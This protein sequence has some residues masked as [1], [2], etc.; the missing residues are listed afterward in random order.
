MT[1]DFAGKGGRKPPANAICQG[2]QN[3]GHSHNGR[4]RAQ[5]AQPQDG[6]SHLNRFN[7]KGFNLL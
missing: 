6:N 7:L 1:Y 3:Q 2:R 4:T 5:P